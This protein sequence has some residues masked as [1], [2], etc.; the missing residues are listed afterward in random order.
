MKHGWGETEWRAEYWF[1]T[2][3]GTS[4]STGNPGTLPT[5]NGI[6]VPTYVRHYDGVFLL[7]LQNI[8]NA[9]HQLMVKYDWYDPNIKVA[10]MELGKAGTNLTPADVKFTTLGMGYAFHIN[11]QTKIILYYDLVKNEST[12]LAGF[13]TDLKDNILTCRIQFRF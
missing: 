6:P 10:K 13:T 7:F 3:P 11:S 1:G 5:S 9:K 2:Q 8:I 12:Q 4:G